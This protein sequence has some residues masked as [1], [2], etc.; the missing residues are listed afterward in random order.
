VGLR[1]A[2]TVVTTGSNDYGD[3][4]VSGWSNIA[5]I[6]CGLQHTVGLLRDTTAPATTAA[7]AVDGT[8]YKAAV[9]MSFTATD[10]AGGSGVARTEYQLDGGAWTK[11][12][13]FTLSAPAD[14]TGDLLHAV[15]YRSADNA[16]NV[17]AAKTITVGIDTRKPTTKAPYAASV[18]RY[19]TAT[20]NYRVVDAAP[21]AGTATVTIRIKNSASQL[22]KTLGP[23]KGKGV[24][25]LLAA[26]FTCKLA[27][28]SYR[29]F[30]NAT[31][32]AGNAQVLPVGSNKLTVR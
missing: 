32:A 22:V 23:Y 21:N 12:T 27:K 17:E 20:L 2:G 18:V 24:N 11:G 19:R 31:D 5:Q 3:C 7:G 30:V 25:K 9:T 13:S 29:F 14:H 1:S 10:N 6:S 28:G 16:G 4:D 8:W 26:T 15:L